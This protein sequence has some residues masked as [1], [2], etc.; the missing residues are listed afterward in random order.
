MNRR[1]TAKDVAERAGV[2]R[3]AVSM[4]VN[5]RDEGMVS[6]DRRARI[7]EAARELGYTPSSVA[8]S[9]R[10]QRTRTIGLV[11]DEIASGAYA[12]DIVLGATDAAMAAGYLLLTVDTHGDRDRELPAYQ[13]LIDRQVD[14]LVFA[15]L[16]LRTYEPPEGLARQPAI[17]A[18]CFDPGGRIPGVVADEVAGGRAAARVLLDAGHRDVV[19]LGGDPET[20]A[21]PR[22]EQGVAEAFAEAGLPVPPVV[23]AGWEI[24][25]GVRAA[26]LALR[27]DPRPTALLCAND[28]V[29]VG[30]VLAAGRLGLD[31]PTDLS[32]LGYDDDP[33]VAR[34]MVPA[35]TT[36]DLPHRAIGEAAMVALLAHLDDGLPL[37]TADRL[38][39]CE[40]VVRDS[41]AAPGRR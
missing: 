34:R 7:L 40:P 20:I 36:I 30:A 10:N 26:T 25:G 16:G 4:V 18:N 5:G 33:N 2:A 12:G 35:L 1:P 41:V 39:P 27:G 29:A 23:R 22:R 38:L 9:L 8:R 37:P 11:T 19:A 6:P 13:T 28:R 15:A 14:A 24:D 32:V 17:L 3:S 21:A 31:V